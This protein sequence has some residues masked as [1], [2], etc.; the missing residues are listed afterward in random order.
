MPENAAAV[1]AD[2]SSE[3][4]DFDAVS[5]DLNFDVVSLNEE[6]AMHNRS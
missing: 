4:L 2:I 6:L 3:A 1:A 5:E